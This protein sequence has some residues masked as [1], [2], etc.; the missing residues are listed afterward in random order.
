MAA[1]KEEG[2]E[3]I[4]ERLSIPET[5]GDSKLWKPQRFEFFE[6][7][8]K[9]LWLMFVAEWGDR[10]QIAMIGLHSSQPLIPVCIGSAAAFLVLTASAVLVASCVGE[11]SLSERMVKG[12]SA[13]SFAVF[14]L[15]A[16][17]DG[18][19]ARQEEIQSL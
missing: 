19:K 11:G 17:H 2:E 8:A 9:S 10:T 7:F 3:Q 13:A 4:H 12:V 15:L 18:M 16:L 6:A 5:K 14:T 1:G